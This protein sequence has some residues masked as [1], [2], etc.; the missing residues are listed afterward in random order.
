MGHWT[1]TEDKPSS[2]VEI[3]QGDILQPTDALKA[4]LADVHPHFL[5]DKYL[6][7]IV[8]TQSCDLVRR[9]A[10][11]KASYINLAVI[12][13]L[14]QVIG[15]LLSY[16][17]TPVAPG[18]FRRSDK[19][20][21]RRLLGR[22]LN[23]NEQA[24]GLFFLCQ[25]ADVGIGEHA[26]A[27]LRVSVALRADHYDALRDAR[28]GR[29]EPEFRAKLGWLVGNLYVRPATRDWTDF[30]GGKKRSDQLVTD[31]LDA[32]RWIDDEIVKV[33][34]VK[35]VPLDGVSDEVL[36]SLKPPSKLER[37]LHEVT[38]EL[39]RIAPDF[40]QAERVKLSN[41]LSSNGKF[42]K[43]FGSDSPSDSST[44]SL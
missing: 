23:Q 36:E 39:A 40:P 6:G 5:S 26:V 15:K 21:A 7:F 18:A 44:D 29:L 9:S 43:L 17:A 20:T 41:R 33:A 4:I 13:P 10:R 24:M 42:T 31:C 35:D 30:D 25:D 16:A 37:A 34:R 12:R 14:S 38:A 28:T 3:E 8:T 11:L 22:L 19:G 27:F 2:E 32:V 1:Y